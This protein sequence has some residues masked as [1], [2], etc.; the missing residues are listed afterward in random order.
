MTLTSR[1]SRFPLFDHFPKLAHRLPRV[2]L[3]DGPSPVS[4]LDA[5]S[6]RTS[7]E[8]WIKNDGLYGTLYGGNKPRKLEFVLPRALATGARTVM[9]T[10]PLGTH[11]G[12]ATALY[13]R[14]LGLNVA[15]L[16]TYQRPSAHVVRQICLMH[17]AGARMHY[18]RSGPLLAVAAPLLALTYAGRDHGRRPYMLP[19]GGS[20][21][22]G[23]LGYVNGALELA[24]Q[25]RAGQLPEPE[26]I[27]LPVGTG[28]TAAGLAL[29]IGLAGLRTRIVGV[30]ITRAPTTWALTVKRL[31]LAT[32]GLM[33]RSGLPSLEP[34]I[35]DVSITGRWL[36]GG[37]GRPTARSEEA[38]HA[39]ARDAGVELEPTYT[40]KTVAGLVEMCEAG[41]F[42]GPVLYW[43]TYDA[44]LAGR[45]NCG[46]DE[47][48]ALPREFRRFCPSQPGG[49]AK[50]HSGMGSL[51]DSFS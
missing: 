46:P 27:V 9:T 43:H 33:R 29:G 31:A 39:M 51:P 44:R 4:R 18:V 2:A 48:A 3:F 28:G 8:I 17:Q 11:H 10:G 21:P 49:R 6:K 35:A 41:E 7:A 12:V 20:T 34:L 1:A 36:G 38:A 32:A 14:R 22:L 5:L 19:P 50:P 45:D 25:V 26:A 23:A 30:A 40:A 24:A 37:Y 15:L 47:W 13:G 42:R 16:L